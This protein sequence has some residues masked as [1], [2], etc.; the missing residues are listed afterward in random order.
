MGLIKKAIVVGGI[1]GVVK[2]YEHKDQRE[3]AQHQEIAAD[4]SVV[5]YHP[6][7]KGSWAERTVNGLSRAVNDTSAKFSK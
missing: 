4:G 7:P 1:V 2:H 5:E 6:A 3:A